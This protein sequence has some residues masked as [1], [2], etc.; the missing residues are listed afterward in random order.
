MKTLDLGPISTPKGNE[1]VLWSPESGLVRYIADVPYWVDDA[2]EVQYGILGSGDRAAL[3]GIGNVASKIG[4]GM[5]KTLNTATAFADRTAAPTLGGTI[6]NIASE[7]APPAVKAAQSAADALARGAKNVV[8]RAVS[9][10]VASQ[11]QQAAPAAQPIPTAQPAPASPP[12]NWQ[13]KSQSMRAGTFQ[14]T[15]AAVP[16]GAQPTAQV[17]PQVPQA[18]SQ[19]IQEHLAANPWSHGHEL[20]SAFKDY[21]LPPGQTMESVLQDMVNRGILEHRQSRPFFR[22]T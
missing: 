21:G 20:A 19:K 5:S 8:G 13:Q 1:R 18:V 9:K 6:K 15:P 4:G 11:P 3:Q 17:V 22:A 14:P 16:A 7:A 2:G 10:P 12:L